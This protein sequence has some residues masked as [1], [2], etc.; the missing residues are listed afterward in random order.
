[1]SLR[2]GPDDERTCTYLNYLQSEGVWWG[3]CVKKKTDQNLWGSPTSSHF[4][5]MIL[6]KNGDVIRMN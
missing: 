2:V 1:M 3:T 6:Q 5:T 4:F